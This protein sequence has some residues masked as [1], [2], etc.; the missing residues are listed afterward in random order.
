MYQ[1]LSRVRLFCAHGQYSPPGSSVRG[2]LQARILEEVA[3]SSSTEVKTECK[4]LHVTNTHQFLLQT[5]CVLRLLPVLQIS[6]LNPLLCSASVFPQVWVWSFSLSLR[7]LCI[8]CNMAPSIPI[9]RGCLSLYHPLD[10]KLHENRESAPCEIPRT[11]KN[12]WRM[13]FTQ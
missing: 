3:L 6:A 8:S 7:A 5:Q 12:A 10:C 11:Q 4:C 2:I 1:L 13:V 9:A